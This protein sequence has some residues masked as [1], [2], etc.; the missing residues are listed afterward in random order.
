[1]TARERVKVA[2]ARR[3]LGTARE[4]VRDVFGLSPQGRQEAVA[5]SLEL[6]GDVDTLLEVALRTKGENTDA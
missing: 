2:E 3:K 4:R 5:H 1:M 6:L